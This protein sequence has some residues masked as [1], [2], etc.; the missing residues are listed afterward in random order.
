MVPISQSSVK[1]LFDM[2]LDFEWVVSGDL[3][4]EFLLINVPFRELCDHCCNSPGR[5]S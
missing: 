5:S 4:D 2:Y 3:W 1:D